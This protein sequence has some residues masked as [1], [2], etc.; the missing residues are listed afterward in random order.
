MVIPLLLLVRNIDSNNV[1]ILNRSKTSFLIFA[2][3]PYLN[4]MHI[5][6]LLLIRIL[7]FALPMIERGFHPLSP[8]LNFLTSAIISSLDF[9]QIA[10]GHISLLLQPNRVFGMAFPNLFVSSSNVFQRI[11]H[12]RE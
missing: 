12:L 7:C 8:I 4:V 11:G 6:Q 5:R 3:V 10:I 2:G 1:C 9:L